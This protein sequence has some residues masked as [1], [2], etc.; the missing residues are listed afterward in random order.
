MDSRVED[1]TNLENPTLT[2][3][4][5]HDSAGRHPY[6]SRVDQRKVEKEM[7]IELHRL[8]D[9][10]LIPSWTNVPVDLLHSD[11]KWMTTKDESTSLAALRRLLDRAL[12]GVPTLVDGV[13]LTSNKSAPP[14][15]ICKWGSDDKHVDGVRCPLMWAM[16]KN[17]G[18][19]G[20]DISVDDKGRKLVPWLVSGTTL[21]GVVV[22]AAVIAELSY[23]AHDPK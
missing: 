6:L 9:P 14:T 21:A 3:Y 20:S 17:A 10:K 2:L 15:S 11:G 5:E 13:S 8:I 4:F 1:K 7:K 22:Q 19:P 16:T 23:T 18:A 12:A